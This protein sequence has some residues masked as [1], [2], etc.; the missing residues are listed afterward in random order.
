MGPPGGDALAQYRMP[1]GPTDNAKAPASP[2]SGD[3]LVI[4]PLT[5]LDR[6]AGAKGTLVA[7]D[8]PAAKASPV[9]DAKPGKVT[10][11]DDAPAAKTASAADAPAAKTASASDAPAAKTAPAADAP[12]HVTT[13]ALDASMVKATPAVDS[14]A[15]GTTP[16]VE[17]AAITATPPVDASFRT[18]TPGVDAP[19][20]KTSPAVEAHAGRPAAGADGPSAAPGA[21]AGQEHTVKHNDSL[22]KIAEQSLGGKDHASPGQIWHQVQS[23]IQA[24]RQEHPELLKNPNMIHEGMKLHVPHPESSQGPGHHDVA[25]RAESFHPQAGHRHAGHPSAGYEHGR[26]H[27]RQGRH[28]QGHVPEGGEAARGARPEPGHPGDEGAPR[29]L[30]EKSTEVPKNPSGRPDSTPGSTDNGNFAHAIESLGHGLASIA[31][32]VA[33]S[34]RTVGDCA[35]G[36]RLAFGKLGFHLPPAV[37]TEQGRMIRNSGLFDQVP[38]SQVRPGDYGVRDWSAAVTRAHGGV[39]KGDAFIVSAVGPHGQ[40]YGAN[41]HH[42]AVPPDGGRYRNLK[43]YRPN[44]EFIKRYGEVQS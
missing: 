33:D 24:N 22:W 15:R 25:S 27:G 42:F 8:T 39:N 14:A 2:M 18:S 20:N 34:L 3:H 13:P 1:M 28:H 29:P 36:P 30:P 21:A 35:H 6:A 10:H 40:L 32:R 5:G 17:A 43:F 23:I 37:A 19:A 44:A 7:G 11:A 38:P 26:H 9:G 12:G 4:P 16:A 41:D 31:N